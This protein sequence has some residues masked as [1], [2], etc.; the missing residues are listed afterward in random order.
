[1]LRLQKI[2]VIVVNSLQEALLHKVEG[3]VFLKYEINDRGKIH[4][5]VVVNGIGYGCDKE[6][7]RIVRLLRYP[8]VKNR[9]V[10]VNTKFK[11]TIHFNLPKSK[12]IRIN[13]IYT[14]S[15]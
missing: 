10:K 8:S 2:G 11:I 3:K 4:D 13:Y 1:M 7:K 9:G 15:S 6:S 5:V 12:Q 14:K